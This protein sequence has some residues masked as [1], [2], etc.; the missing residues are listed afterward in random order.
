[1]MNDSLEYVINDFENDLKCNSS[2]DVLVS[3][4][5]VMHAFYNSIHID[6]DE[7]QILLE[8][9]EKDIL[10]VE[11]LITLLPGVKDCFSVNSELFPSDNP[12]RVINLYKIEWGR[13]GWT[14]DM[15]LESLVNCLSRIIAGLVGYVELINTYIE[16]ERITQSLRQ[17]FD[18]IS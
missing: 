9:Q 11:S 18:N 6:M 15:I 14:D 2:S 1:M 13:P 8:S 4:T 7:L 12:R 17:L 16:K 5:R 3:M 10:L